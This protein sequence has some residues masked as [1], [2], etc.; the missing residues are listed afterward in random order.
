MSL[1]TITAAGLVCSVGHDVDAA[2]AA[3]RC[4]LDHV[5]E[6]R[7]H[8]GRSDWLR[9]AAVPDEAQ[10]HGFD[11]W[12]AMLEPAVV[13][14]LD[15][16]GR[17]R[18]AIVLLRPTAAGCDE[19]LGDDLADHLR[20]RFPAVAAVEVKEPQGFTV[21]HAWAEVRERLGVTA[22]VIAGVDSLLTAAAI[23]P[24][25]DDGTLIGPT[26]ISQATAGEAAAAVLC[27]DDG[28]GLHCLGVAAAPEPARR[29]GRTPLKADGLTN[30]GRQALA[31]AG[32]AMHDIAWRIADCQMDQR[33]LK[34]AALVHRRLSRQT[35][36]RCPLWQ[37]CRST[38]LVGAA[39]VPLLL[40]VA[41]MA[42]RKGYAPGDHVLLHAGAGDAVRS[43]AVCGRRRN[44]SE[45]VSVA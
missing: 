3:I 10:R 41:W 20:Q 27:C 36:E 9:V 2:C 33:S 39:T 1:P 28:E 35:R 15:A 21:L 24:L 45:V 34:E 44:P 4:G 18:T 7:F 32:V 11:R 43:V 8:D 40:A 19:D 13:A 14:C 22:C 6:S 25:L 26:G 16:A 37:P 17:A 12:W 31:E 29:G 5:V 42:F 23:M 38:G 30:A